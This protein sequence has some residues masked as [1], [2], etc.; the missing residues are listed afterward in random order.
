MT[1]WTLFWTTLA[2]VFAVGF[3]VW[4]SGAPSPGNATE[5]A[6][7][8]QA[9]G[10]IGAIVVAI[11]VAQHSAKI[12][13]RVAL[14]MQNREAA[15]RIEVAVHIANQANELRNHLKARIN[16]GAR[17][18]G[19]NDFDSV[20]DAIDVLPFAELRSG[21]LVAEL[22]TTRRLVRSLHAISQTFESFYGI[23]EP[24]GL[25]S[26]KSQFEKKSEAL[27]R[28]YVRLKGDAAEALKQLSS[29][30]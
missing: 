7:W 23:L 2:V 27:D 19:D 28:T 1:N 20:A 13:R 11:L 4:I 22:M 21:L 17:G 26:L 18:L 6:A 16:G 9:I 29:L 25:E 8:L 15:G 3:A 24:A 12:S 14:E 5:A 30:H 10:S